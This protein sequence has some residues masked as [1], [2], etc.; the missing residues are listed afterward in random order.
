MAAGKWK[1]VSIY[2][3]IIT[4]IEELIAKEIILYSN[5]NQYC[6]AVIER[7]LMEIIK[8]MESQ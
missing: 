7:A 6:N 8:N 4:K 3:P 1:S 5:P 2:S